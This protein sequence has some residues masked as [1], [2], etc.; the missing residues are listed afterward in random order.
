MCKTAPWGGR[1]KFLWCFFFLTAHLQNCALGGWGA[2]AD[3]TP[4]RHDVN[5]NAM[6]V[7]YRYKESNYGIT[8]M[9]SCN[10]IMDASANNSRKLLANGNTNDK[11]DETETTGRRNVKRKGARSMFVGAMPKMMK[12]RWFFQC[13]QECGPEGMLRRHHDVTQKGISK[14]KKHTV[15]MFFI[16]IMQSCPCEKC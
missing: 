8:I 11:N 10:D 14:G 1:R 2:H 5:W 13:F 3:E 16:I 12:K 6:V 15:A 9:T 4:P 7:Q